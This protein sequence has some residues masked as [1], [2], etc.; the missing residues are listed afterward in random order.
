MV[1]RVGRSFT[2]VTLSVIAPSVGP[3]SARS[4][5]RVAIVAATSLSVAGVKLTAAKAVLTALT[6]PVIAHTPV[7]LV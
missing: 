5:T 6:V 7:P 3:V 2:A 1:E 4:R